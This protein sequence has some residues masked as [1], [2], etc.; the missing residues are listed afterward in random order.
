MMMMNKFIDNILIKKN[1]QLF[2]NFYFL[3]IQKLNPNYIKEINSKLI[4]EI[5]SKL[6][7]EINSKLY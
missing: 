1:L 7:K 3:L 5:N 2:V 6:I 4:K